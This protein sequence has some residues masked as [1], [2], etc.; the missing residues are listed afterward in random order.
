MDKKRKP[1][2]HLRLW[3]QVIVAAVTNGYLIGFV[4]GKIFTGWT[5]QLCVPGLNCY[6]CPGALGSCPIGSLQAVLGSRNYKFAFYVTGFLMV[7]GAVFGRFVCGWLCPFG[8]VQ[9]LLY[10]IPFF[11]KLR[12]LPG[13]RWLKYLKY[14]ILI[15][16]VILLP[17][18]AV[19]IVGQG[20]PWFCK[21]ICPAGTLEGGI[22]LV[23]SNSAL[24]AAVGWLFAWKNLLLIALI[25]LSIPVY[26]PFCRYLC[27]LGAI[28]GLFNPIAFYRY[29]I[30][31]N[32]CTRCRACQKACKLDIPVYEKPNSPDC[33][34]CGAC[35]KACPHHAICSTL[36]KQKKEEE[37]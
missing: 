19:D 35:K 4:K 2:K 18:F 21:Y 34:R 24:Q 15:G 36:K 8:L 28:Y 31:R 30:D 10:K 11:K 23:F 29:K 26:R 13:D 22:P 5:K 12:K 25:L 14:V 1:V 37:V 32:S 9:D 17:L 27:P 20:S 6:S 16:F 33:I 3:V 7:V